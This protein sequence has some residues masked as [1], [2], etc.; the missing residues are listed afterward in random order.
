[1]T[2][3]VLRTKVELGGTNIE[4]V[5]AIAAP[6]IK[7]SVCTL[8]CTPPKLTET[9][10]CGSSHHHSSRCAFLS[11]K[12]YSLCVGAHE[13]LQGLPVVSCLIFE[14]NLVCV[15]HLGRTKLLLNTT[16]QQVYGAIGKASEIQ[17][18][19]HRYLLTL[20]CTAYVTFG[21]K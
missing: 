12:Q 2:A 9:R 19:Q 13:T 21:G 20:T 1:M 3:H 17:E 7:S 8:S 18:R 15:C 4:F 5:P 16:L 14:V 10:R 6:E 11:C